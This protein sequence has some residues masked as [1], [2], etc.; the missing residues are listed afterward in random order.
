MRALAI[1]AAG[2]ALLLAA[3]AGAADVREE[4]AYYVAPGGAALGTGTLYAST[5]TGNVGLARATSRSGETRVR[6]QVT[7]SSG[8]PVAVRIEAIRG[9]RIDVLVACAVGS[10]GPLA[11][12]GPTELRV[13]PLIGPCGQGAATAASTPTSG[14]VSFTFSR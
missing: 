10:L 2:S 8:L 1:V 9:G 11:L 12:K 13:L 7:D 5:P 3:P 6:M 4:K 14:E